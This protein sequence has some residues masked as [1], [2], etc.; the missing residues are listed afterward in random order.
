MIKNKPLHW[1]FQFMVDSRSGQSG[2]FAVCLVVSEH[3]RGSDGVT[4]LCLLTVDVVVLVQT[5]RYAPAR[6][7]P[8]LVRIPQ[9]RCPEVPVQV[10]TKSA[11]LSPYS[12]WQLVRVVGL[13]GMLTHL[14][15]G[16]QNQGADLQ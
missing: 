16:Q 11:P 3:R 10:V 7:S 8:A 6:G 12:G 4:N 15:S 1:F 2:V 13:G 5:R 9:L 14:R